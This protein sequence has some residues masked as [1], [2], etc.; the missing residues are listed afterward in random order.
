MIASRPVWLRP[1]GPAA[2][3]RPPSPMRQ[4]W[5]HEADPM[6][7]DPM[8]PRHRVRLQSYSEAGPAAECNKI[9]ELE[10]QSY[11]APVL[12]GSRPSGSDIGRASFPPCSA[13]RP[14]ALTLTTFSSAAHSHHQLVLQSIRPAHATRPCMF[15]CTA[16]P[17]ACL[18]RRRPA[19][20]SLSPDPTE[21]E[22]PPG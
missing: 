18:A 20:G 11:S 8:P 15:E 7:G 17:P 6:E 10:V 16:P 2:F 3:F 21:T 14:H 13:M 19:P 5:V 12:L 1:Q 9:T 22:S 4:G